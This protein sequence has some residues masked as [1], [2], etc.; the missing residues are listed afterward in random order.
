MSRPNPLLCLLLMGSALFL[1]ITFEMLPIGMLSSLTDQLNTTEQGVGLMVSVWAVVVVVTA[2]PLSAAVARVNAR[3]GLVVSLVIL[4]V[5]AGIL[6]VSTGLAVALV[7][8][9]ISGATFAVLSTCAS[10]LAIDVLSPEHQARAGTTVAVG[11]A[12]ALSVGVPLANAM[13]T[14]ADHRLPFITVG[15]AFVVLAALILLL[16]PADL[17]HRSDGDQMSARETFIAA[18]QRPLLKMGATI[19]L[20]LLAHYT[21]YSYI[22]PLL[23]EAGVSSSTVSVVLLS[24]GAAGIVGL[25]IG[26]VA[27]ERHPSASLWTVV[28]VIILALTA[29]VLA[30]DS[31]VAAAVTTVFWGLAFGAMPVVVQVL[32][33]RSTPR[34]PEAAQ[35]VVNMSFNIGITVGSL[36]GGV[37]VANSAPSTAALVAA[38]IFAGTLALTMLPHWLPGRTAI[39]VNQQ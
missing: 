9:A 4:A 29:L 15:V 12:L 10:R 34:Q 14:I 6:T 5:C 28:T 11:N 27:V 3:T 7:S 22:E 16:I 18:A 26:S 33:F 32:A 23:H 36:L 17:D 21:V 2:V 8:R 1:S 31:A 38:V 20:L 39:V 24:Y 19:A 25:I 13:V 35:P 30:R 37:V